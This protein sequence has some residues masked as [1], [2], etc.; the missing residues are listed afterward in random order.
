MVYVR[1]EKQIWGVIIYDL[2][3]VKDKMD[4]GESSM[5]STNYDY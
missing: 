1:N 4:Y 2:F 5:R 3:S